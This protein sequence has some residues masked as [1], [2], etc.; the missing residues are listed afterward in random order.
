MSNLNLKWYIVQCFTGKEL[1]VKNKIEQKIEA[2]EMKQWIEEIYVPLKNKINKQGQLAFKVEEGTGKKKLKKT[3][4]F[5]GYIFVKM[6]QASD[7]AWF[8]IR[9]TEG[10]NGIIGSSGKGIKPTPV[11]TKYIENLKV[12]EKNEVEYLEDTDLSDV[13][14][15][16]QKGDPLEIVSG[17]YIGKIGKVLN[18]D[19]GIER[20]T[21]EIE[22]MGKMTPIS[23]SIKEVKVL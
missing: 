17:P 4:K 2:E 20:V 14:I 12:L 23:L 6:D 5:S 15:H 22:T 8:L 21:L 1:S 16:F 13:K 19:H 7:D 11:D 18:I 9:N 3:P 10:V